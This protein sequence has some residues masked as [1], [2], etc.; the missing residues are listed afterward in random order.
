M[1][2]LLLGTHSVVRASILGASVISSI[3]VARIFGPENLGAYNL[4]LL[5][6][7]F[8]TFIFI[9]PVG[10]F[11]LRE[12]YNFI[13][14]KQLLNVLCLFFL[15][16]LSLSTL[17][18]IGSGFQE[19]YFE[20]WG[21]FGKAL[22]GFLIFSNIVI[23]GLFFTLLTG[24][25]IL[26]RVFAFSLVSISY[27]IFS[28]LLP[29]LIISYVEQ[30]IGY[31]L[32]G[33][34]L[35]QLAFLLIVIFYFKSSGFLHHW[36]CAGF[37]TFFLHYRYSKIF[38]FSIPLSMASMA[39]FA[40]YNGFKFLMVDDVGIMEYGRFVAAYTIAAG[41]I[42]IV[43]QVI[44]AVYQPEIYKNLSEDS[45][46]F[47]ISPWNKSIE[48]L[49]IYLIGMSGLLFLIGQDLILFLY[50]PDFDGLDGYLKLAILIECLRVLAT[51]NLFYFQMTKRTLFQSFFYLIAGSIV[52]FSF[53]W[54]P[55]TS[56]VERW[57]MLIATGV[58]GGFISLLAYLLS[59]RAYVELQYSRIA[60][61]GIAVIITG[62]FVDL[63]LEMFS[64][65]IIW[66]D[67]IIACG[68]FFGI[69]MLLDNLFNIRFL[70]EKKD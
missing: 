33:V 30:S 11:I 42:G 55:F 46:G 31:W 65:K 38:Y 20:E 57:L 2:L 32:L 66:L 22:I 17:L 60:T 9:G 27:A 14:S 12:V 18:F 8:V 1:K 21:L 7:N 67:L 53:T 51:S 25:N 5:S 24:I 4:I 10:S 19:Y 13:D 40:L 49:A 48:K 56:S 47:A 52:F 68:L 58:M 50:G 34:G 28:I 15:Y 63:L 61:S 45:V 69:F 6:F 43:E 41:C 36:S 54:F 3:L 29:F 59:K 39:S 26:G 64:I 70:V 16:L 37:K 35:V 44:T 62:A 23:A